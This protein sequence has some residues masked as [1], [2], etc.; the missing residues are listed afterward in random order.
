[1]AVRPRRPAR[2]AAARPR[3]RDRRRARGLRR[4]RPGRGD[5]NGGPRPR[6]APGR[7]PARQQRRHPG[8]RAGRRRRSRP[9]RARRARRT[10]S[11]ACGR[12]AHCF[13][14]CAAA[15]PHGGAHVVDVVSIA[16]TIA[17][18]PAGAY[19]ASKHAQLAFSRSLRAA[20]R[21]SGIDVHT[22]LPGYVQT[23][24]FPQRSLMEHRLLRRIVAQPDDV[25]RAIL[26]AVERGRSEVVVPWFPYRL[27]TVLNGL[28]PTTRRPP[29][30]A[31]RAH[32]P[33][34]PRQG[35]RAVLPGDG[36]SGA[37]A[38][39]AH[40]GRHRGVVRH[41][42][43]DRAAALR[44]RLAVRARRT[45]RA[46]FSA[47]SPPRSGPRSKPATSPSAMRSRP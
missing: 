5:G 3:G 9:P 43:G 31:R 28:A 20:L 39:R 32:E 24:G 30:R 23:E 17:L 42:R 34:V 16:G 13:P 45:T 38:G 41:R 29:R 2:G 33:R 21:G 37:N 14:A 7:A 47:T 18:A 10:T 1:M 44:P 19:A 46:R 40:R 15:A 27:A 35:G 25:G 26:K 4:G 12:P 36:S 22:I 6:P 11:A 8:P